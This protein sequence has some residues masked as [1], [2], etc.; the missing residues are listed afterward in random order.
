M[1]YLYQRL[2]QLNGKVNKY[3]LSNSILLSACE[4]GHL[5]ILKYAVEHTDCNIGQN[6]DECCQ[7]AAKNQHLHIIKYLYD[8]FFNFRFRSSTINK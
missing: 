7:L 6:E 2:D 8:N 3:E 4:G 5:E 1:K